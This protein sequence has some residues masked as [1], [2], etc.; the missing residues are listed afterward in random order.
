MDESSSHAD[1]PSI[2]PAHKPEHA[3]TNDPCCHGP[4][5]K[6]K[7]RNLVISIDGTS[8]KFGAM[9][10]NVIEHHSLLEDEHQVLYYNSGI[11]TY[12]RPS[13]TSPKFIGMVLHHTIDLAIAWDFDKTVKDAYRW[14]S[15]NYESGDL[16]FMFGFSRGAFQVRVLSAMIEKVGLLRPGNELR[17]PFA[18]EL[19][20]DPATN[21]PDS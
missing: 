12:A 8:N 9:N 2:G 4:I 13:W 10:T 15:D 20:S 14:I 3:K 17:I 7:R 11:G 1:G 5:D 6:E 19:Y 16:I 18:Y 21:E